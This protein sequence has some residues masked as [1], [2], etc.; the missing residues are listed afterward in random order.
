MALDPE[1]L[2]LNRLSK[3]IAK[4]PKARQEWAASWLL[5][6][7]KSGTLNSNAAPIALFPSEVSKASA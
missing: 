7:A 5:E 3:E 6:K 1:L 4:L 2:V